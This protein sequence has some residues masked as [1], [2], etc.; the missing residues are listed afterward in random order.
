MSDEVSIDG[1]QYISSRRAAEITGYAQ[2]YVGQLARRGHIDA[3][4]VGGLWYISMDSLQ[5]Y[6]EQ[7]DAYKPIQPQRGNQQEDPDSLISFDGRDHISAAK[8]SKIT[9]YHQDYVGQLARSGAILSRQVG[10][11]WYV[12]R[13]GILAHKEEKDRLLA[14]VQVESVGLPRQS[15][16]SPA[17]APTAPQATA[18]LYK[19]TR[20]E[21]DLLP[22]LNKRQNLAVEA[23]QGQE[24]YSYSRTPV[25]IRV[26]RTPAIS[27]M[28]HARHRQQR[29]K[30]SAIPGK[31]MFYGTFGVAVATI[32]IV[33]SLG[34]PGIKDA[35]IYAIGGAGKEGS[36]SNQAL[37]ASAYKAIQRLGDI[38]EVY[39]T[40]ELIYRRD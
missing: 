17:S 31:T 20:D 33:L 9:G 37:T 25:P 34:F 27:T 23:S 8:A 5:Q 24:P 10:N 13:A 12:E 40:K 11:R 6:K 38:L 18:E 7:A 22:T 26:M 14:A 28:H 3:K 32:V 30:K 1:K 29:E 2:D 39:L 15:Q 36:V 16:G 21:R 19:Y 4:R 35:A